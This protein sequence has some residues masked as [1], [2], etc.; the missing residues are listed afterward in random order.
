MRQRIATS[1]N[2]TGALPMMASM[3]AFTVNDALMKTLSGEMPL[4]Q[5]LFLRGVL[6]TIAVAAIAW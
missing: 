4:L 1:D 5:L 2:L 3:A 6:T